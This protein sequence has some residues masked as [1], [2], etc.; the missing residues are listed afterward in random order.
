[1]GLFHPSHAK[2]RHVR[3]A[4]EN[5]SGNQCLR[6][7]AAMVRWLVLRWGVMHVLLEVRSHAFADF[8][9]HQRRRMQDVVF[10]SHSPVPRDTTGV[11][12]SANLVDWNC[13][14]RQ[15]Y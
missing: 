5:V 8:N 14:L 15:I 1:M 7:C 12:S 11:S 10:H 2:C 3:R 9:C 13:E 4:V 6:G